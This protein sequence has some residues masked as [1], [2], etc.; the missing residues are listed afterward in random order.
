[1]DGGVLA[2]RFLDLGLVLGLV[3]ER[4]AADETSAVHVSG[5]HPCRESGRRGREQSRTRLSAHEQEWDLVN[6]KRDDQPR[7]DL[8]ET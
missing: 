4:E 3:L 6:V 7:S 8:N 5:Q 2:G 1:V